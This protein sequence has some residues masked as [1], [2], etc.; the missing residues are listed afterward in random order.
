LPNILKYYIN[1]HFFG[2]KSTYT[3]FLCHIRSILELWQCKYSVRE[4]SANG[5]QRAAD[6]TGYDAPIAARFAT[7]S[8]LRA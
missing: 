7:E 5:E 4:G 3:T 6:A 2:Q 1:Q 8:S